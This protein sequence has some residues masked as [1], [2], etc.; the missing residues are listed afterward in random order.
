MEYIS[1]IKSNP[2]QSPLVTSVDVET[3]NNRN[4]WD[5]NWQCKSGTIYFNKKTGINGLL[6]QIVTKT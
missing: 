3:D 4:F 5:D 6:N 2:Q 1:N